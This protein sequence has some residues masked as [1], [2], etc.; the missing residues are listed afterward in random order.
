V[1]GDVCAANDGR[2]RVSGCGYHLV[3]LG[4][5]P[6]LTW[7]VIPV[8]AARGS[9]SPAPSRHRRRV[10][11]RDCSRRS[12][13]DGRPCCCHGRSR[14]SIGPHLSAVAGQV[15]CYRSKFV[16]FA[17]GAGGL[18]IR[19]V[20]PAMVHRLAIG[21][22]RQSADGVNHGPRRPF[23]HPVSSSADR[24]SAVRCCR[25]ITRGETEGEPAPAPPYMV[26]SRRAYRLPSN[27]SASAFAPYSFRKPSIMPAE[28]TATARFFSPS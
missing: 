15:F 19:R 3:L 6:C 28:C 11:G 17:M 22:L 26:N 18:R 21:S 4:R 27:S 5:I 23:P 25:R 24:H 9:D 13:G 20:G 1:A 8:A 10:R 16:R 2:G 14:G 12:S 7:I